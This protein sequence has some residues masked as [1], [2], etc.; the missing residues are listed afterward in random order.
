MILAKRD[1]NYIIGLHSLLKISQRV[2]L[3]PNLA[4]ICPEIVT[5][6]LGGRKCFHLLKTSKQIIQVACNIHKP[7]LFLL[8]SSMQR[9]CSASLRSIRFILVRCAG[10][11]SLWYH[12]ISSICRLPKLSYESPNLL[13]F[14]GQRVRTYER[15][16]S[17]HNSIPL[18]LRPDNSSTELIDKKQ[19]Y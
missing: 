15:D 19:S 16:C 4:L 10:T 13:A 7:R 6:W 17:N 18:S 14:L 9:C 3:W 8:L 5:S 11:D 1:H 2:A 12:M